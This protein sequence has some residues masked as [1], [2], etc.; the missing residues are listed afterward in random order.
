MT[1]NGAGAGRANAAQ[2]TPSTESRLATTH[3]GNAFQVRGC[4][5]R[6]FKVALDVE[7]T[8]GES[9]ME[10]LTFSRA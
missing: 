10:L 9:I 5:A 7:S 8:L 3:F 1:C 2:I 4:A 6:E